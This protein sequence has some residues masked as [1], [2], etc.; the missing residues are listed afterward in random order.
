MFELYVHKATYPITLHKQPSTATGR[1]IYYRINYT[2]KH[3]SRKNTSSLAI[4]H[5]YNIMQ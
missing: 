1:C 5:I 2:T 3:W 4:F